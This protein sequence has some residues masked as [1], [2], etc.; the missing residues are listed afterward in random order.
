MKIVQHPTPNQ[1]PELLKRPAK[2][3]RALEASVGAVMQD[4]KQRGDEAL[5]EYTSTFD[6]VDISD[7]K[8]AKSE[9]TAALEAISPELRAAIELAI[10]NVARFHRTQITE[11]VVVETMPGVTCW[12][13]S[14]A[15]DKVGLYIPGGTAP[16][17]ST[18]VMLATPALLA[19]CKEI[20]LCSPPNKEG[21]IHPAILAA[22]ALCGVTQVFKLGG[23]QAI[24]AMT[25]GTETVPAVYKL[26][27]PGNTYVTVAKQ[28]AVNEGLAID[29]PAGPSEVLVCADEG[30]NPSFVAADLL[31]Q[32]E[33]GADS[34][35]I[36]VAFTK[37]KAEAIL[38]EVEKQLAVLPRQEFAAQS[39]ANSVTIVVKDQNVAAN[40]INAYAPEHLILSMT[41]A[42]EF[43]DRITN[44][45][46]VFL[47]YLTPESVG[48]YA[49][50]TNHTLP[51]YGY[52][53]QYSGVSLDSFVKK[54]TYQELS[55]TG[56]QNLGPSVMT[57]AAAEELEAHRMAVELRLNS[58]KK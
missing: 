43:S 2:D 58:I 57:M 3:F 20:V 53:R 17:F 42:R 47:G 5:K 26:F 4:V 51:T 6:G 1:W 12:R 44:A 19:G 15:I 11:P 50:G 27:G 48:D 32:A 55:A 33:H 13:K 35:V 8:V 14:V 52:A 38:V 49:S 40:V 24:A 45:G 39:I 28:L 9:L 56:I 7:F 29:M 41:D 25:F 21:N 46:S 36:L 23:T 37:E 34:Q 54:I 16:L 30:A 31:S 10:D 22:A 18:V